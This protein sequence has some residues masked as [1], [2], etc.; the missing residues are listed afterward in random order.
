MEKK[1][2]VEMEKFYWG[3]KKHFHWFVSQVKT[4]SQY[5]LK[6]SIFLSISLM[7]SYEEA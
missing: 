3:F 7:L 2:L 1:E 4:I 5:G 6:K